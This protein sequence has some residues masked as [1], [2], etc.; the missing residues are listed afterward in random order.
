M[1]DFEHGEIWCEQEGGP[2]S[3][4]AQG[5]LIPGILM[6]VARRPLLLPASTCR[7]STCDWSGDR[8]VLVA[9][10]IREAPEL[11]CVRSGGDPR[12]RFPLSSVC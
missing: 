12:P 8:L 7:H 10:S 5:S 3:I 11:A 2:V 4:E 1:S 6:D 9:F